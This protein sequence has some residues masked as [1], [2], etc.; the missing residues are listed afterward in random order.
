MSQG[1]KEEPKV[2]LQW[3]DGLGNIPI[4]QEEESPVFRPNFSVAKDEVIWALSVALMVVIVI[5][6]LCILAKCN[7]NMLSRRKRRKI[8]AAERR[9]SVRKAKQEAAAKAEVTNEKVET[10]KSKEP[11]RAIS[12][13]NP[14]THRLPNPKPKS[15]KDFIIDIIDSA[16]TGDNNDTLIVNG[17]D[18]NYSSSESIDRWSHEQRLRRSSATSVT[19]SLVF[20]TEADK[21]V[22]R[23]L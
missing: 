3:Q 15:K 10:T 6:A 16:L 23:R 2:L 20:D 22:F 17:D 14:Q 7:A 21:P 8:R 1:K 13:S 19:L 9:K 5:G 12:K 11:V 4:I 18:V